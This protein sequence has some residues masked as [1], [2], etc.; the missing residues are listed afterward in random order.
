MTSS[1][2][3]ASDL[4]RAVEKANSA[5]S[6]VDA[7]RDLAD[8]QVEAGIP[9]LIEALGYNN[10]GAAVAA[11]DGLVALGD[12]V[13]PTL[14]EQIDGYNY[15]A[16][17]WA[18]RALASIGHPNALETLLHTLETDFSMSVRRAAARG[19]GMLR[20]QLLPAAEIEPAQSQALTTLLPI[21]NDPEWV[22][23]YATVVGLQALA[24]AIPPDHPDWHGKIYDC[25]S[26]MQLTDESLAVRT[27]VQH[28]QATISQ[29]IQDQ[30]NQLNTSTSPDWQNILDQVYQR[31][32]SERP[33]KEGDPRRFKSVAAVMASSTD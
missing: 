28:A 7:V 24:I 17:A 22:V 21:T 10:P 11:V 8:A 12:V 3:S 31:K 27:R 20:W 1:T 25:L 2:P 23:R 15:G 30:S 14:L 5:Q 4:I 26:Q 13:V 33:L 16:R 19:L 18:V 29:F 32:A 9:L 6:L